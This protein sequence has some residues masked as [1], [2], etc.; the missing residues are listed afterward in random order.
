MIP[1][2][3]LAVISL[4][5]AATLR[6]GLTSALRTPRA[7]ALKAAAENRSGADRIARLLESRD[8]LQPAVN[9]VQTF[10]L[11]G[12][13]VPAAWLVAQRGSG[14]QL[15]LTLLGV[16]ILIWLCGDFLARALGRVRP[17]SLA[18]RVAPL[19]STTVRW[20]MAANDFIADDQLAEEDVDEESHEEEEEERELIDSVLEFTDTIVREV[21]VPRQDM[22]TID[23]GANLASLAGLSVE[24][25][26]SRYPLT[27]E[28]DNE[29]IGLVLT[30]DVLGAHAAGQEI[31][32]L[33]PFARDMAF[34]PETKR[35]SDLLREMQANKTHLAMVVDEHGDIVGLVSIEDLLEELV[36]EI[37][38]E[39]DPEE[40]LLEPL[41]DGGFLVDARLEVSELGDAFSV[42]LPDDEW[43]TVGGLVLGLAGRVPEEG[44]KFEINGL[45]LEVTRLQGRRVSEV[46]VHRAQ[47]VSSSE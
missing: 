26:F 6:A 11:I 33:R 28:S 47:P 44:E 5:L 45:Q 24:H 32:D 12:A 37:V 19:L 27:D 23:V 41:S 1:A 10:L 4:A 25:G 17:G 21:M 39:H 14:W 42:T 43:D 38:D 20:G 3:I 13:A 9:A 35:A 8:S 30:K 34:V 7:D 16:A 15:G 2:T 18:Y 46:A 29:V 31:V 22:V 36:G 40:E